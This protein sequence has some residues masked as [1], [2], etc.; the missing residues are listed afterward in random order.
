MFC[1]WTH[2]YTRWTNVKWNTCLDFAEFIRVVIKQFDV[3]TATSVF[4]QTQIRQT[5]RQIIVE[6]RLIQNQRL[7]K[8][9]ILI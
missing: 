4:Q 1:A 6:E 8:C 9:S 2:E 5:L 7:I 3:D